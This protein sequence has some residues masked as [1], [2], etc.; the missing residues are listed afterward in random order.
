MVFPQCWT[1]SLDICL[2]F[3]F[4]SR[5]L[6]ILSS[7]ICRLW[8]SCWIRFHSLFDRIVT[9][10]MSVPL[11]RII[12]LWPIFVPCICISG[13]KGISGV[14]VLYLI[15]LFLP[16]IAL[17]V[18]HSMFIFTT[19]FY[20]I[21]WWL[22][23]MKINNW[24]AAWTVKYLLFFI[25]MYGEALEWPNCLWRILN[26]LHAGNLMK[27]KCLKK[28]HY[29]IYKM[30]YE[31]AQIKLFFSWR[32]YKVWWPKFHCSFKD[33]LY[34]KQYWVLIK[35]IHICRINVNEVEYAS[36][37]MNCDIYK[38]NSKIKVERLI[39]DRL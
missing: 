13:E 38:V 6:R 18:K 20:R 32:L 23:I 8:S 34:L 7:S 15:W 29:Q 36:H 24:H 37:Y 22:K 30:Q 9:S 4:S 19:Q 11:G 1:I 14:P 31:I 3:S 27:K 35:Y 17:T 21:F 39:F 26:C 5:S 28:Y 25:Y 16:D 2:R 33:N 10:L 12:P